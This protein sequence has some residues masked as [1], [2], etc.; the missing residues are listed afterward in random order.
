MSAPTLA[1]ILYAAFGFFGIVLRMW[2]QYRRTGSSGFIG[3]R[4]GAGPAEV[5]GAVLLV[6]GIG[7]GVEAAAEASTGNLEPI[8]ALDAAGVRVVGGALALIGIGFALYAQLA[9]GNS[10]RLGVGSAGDRTELITGGPFELV[11][12]PIYTGMIAGFAGIALLT[13]NW[14]AL[15][16]AAAVLASLE[17]QTRLAE[18]PHLLEVHG[19]AYADYAAGVGR[20]VPGMGRLR[21]R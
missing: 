2:I 12:N 11:R 5:L 6:V 14:L 20:F 15:A 16:S 4:E 1:L 19:Q 13:P 18:E 9:M 7:G 3:L 8:E 17:I 21:R 10:W